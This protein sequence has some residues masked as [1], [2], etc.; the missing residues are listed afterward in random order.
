MRKWLDSAS[1]GTAKFLSS[2]INEWDTSLQGKIVQNLDGNT[3]RYHI[4]V[5]YGVAYCAS[6]TDPEPVAAVLYT[7]ADIQFYNEGQFKGLLKESDYT[8]VE[9]PMKI[10]SKM[11][12]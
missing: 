8:V 11:K 7:D 2:D 1:T 12:V 6:T 3:R 9:E 10:G 4:G 5:V